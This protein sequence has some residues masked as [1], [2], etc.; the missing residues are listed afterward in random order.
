MTVRP[1]NL[2]IQFPSARPVKGR[3]VHATSPP[4]GV[5][6]HVNY[7]ALEH[8][9]IDLARKYID[10]ELTHSGFTR[11]VSTNAAIAVIELFE[12]DNPLVRKYNERSG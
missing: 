5:R 9:L 10:R 12:E 6:V 3:G 1:N 11:Q 2:T 4:H 8:Q 7:N